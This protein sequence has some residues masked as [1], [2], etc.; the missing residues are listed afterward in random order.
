[1][2]LILTMLSSFL[3]MNRYGLILISIVALNG[4][5]GSNNDQPD[6][7]VKNNTPPNVNAGADLSVKE[8]TMARLTGT[9]SD[10]EGDVTFSWSQSSGPN[11]PLSDSSIANPTFSAPQVAQATDLTFTL[12][13]TD[14]EGLKASDSVKVTITDTPTTV[15]A[16]AGEDR[17]VDEGSTVT[18]DGNGS[19]GSQ[20]VTLAWSQTGGPSVTLTGENTTKPSFIAPSVTQSVTLTFKLTVTASAGEA[21]SD[22]VEVKVNDAGNGTPNAFNRRVKTMRID[23]DNN[24]TF[25]TVTTYSYNSDGTLDMMDSIY[26]DDGATDNEFNSFPWGLPRGNEQ[27][28]VSYHNQDQVMTLHT[29]RDTLAY[30]FIYDWVS[31]GKINTAI[32]KNYDDMG[33]LTGQL[34]MS[35]TYD[36]F[37]RVEEVLGI[38]VFP[39]SANRTELKF[40]LSYD[41]A[42]AVASNLQTTTSVINGVMTKQ[43]LNREYTWMSDG[44]LGQVR[45]YNPD[46]ASN[47]EENRHFVYA[48]EQLIEVRN[49]TP[50]GLLVWTLLYDSDGLLAGCSLDIGD[51]GNTEARVQIDWEVGACKELIAFGPGALPSRNKR[52]GDTL[53]YILGDGHFPL[54]GC[55]AVN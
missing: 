4:C 36:S 28:K 2:N 43:Q 17:T 38:S 13:V 12:T 35:V 53:P 37:N 3:A 5:G 20:T 45:E 40:E 23:F 34:D 52:L 39:V 51:N 46:P 16:D 29:S 48:N 31:V 42:G 11:V 9:G 8:G 55:G 10:N 21:I 54:E 6:P 19:A 30:E 27:T 7:D 1:M 22:T 18:L 14:S 26:T 32:N 15:T 41:G 50:K 33:Q 44:A 49:D 25:E 24:S 47:F